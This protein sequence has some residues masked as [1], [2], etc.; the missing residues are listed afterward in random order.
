MATETV[1]PPLAPDFAATDLERREYLLAMREFWLTK[2]DQSMTEARAAADAGDGLTASL[3]LSD[4][5]TAL[6]MSQVYKAES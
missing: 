3:R 2:A 5:H 6:A 1:R 4:A